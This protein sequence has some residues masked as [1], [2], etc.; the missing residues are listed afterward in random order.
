MEQPTEI[1]NDRRSAE[2]ASSGFGPGAIDLVWGR[3]RTGAPAPGAPGDVLAVSEDAFS[4]TYR[5]RRADG[6]TC[7]IEIQRDEV[8][9]E[10]FP[11]A[12]GGVH[13]TVLNAIWRRRAI[14]ASVDA[15]TTPD[16]RPCVGYEAF[17]PL[18]VCREKGVLFHAP[19]PSS[20]RLGTLAD[21]VDAELLARL[22]LPDWATT[23]A[24]FLYDVESV[25]TTSRPRFW[26]AMRELPRG[27]AADVGSWE[28]FAKELGGVVERAAT[29][30][31]VASAQR[32]RFPCIGCD[33]VSKCFAR[34]GAA[35]SPQAPLASRRLAPVAMHPFRAVAAAEDVASF[36]EHCDILGGAPWPA[37]RTRHMQTWAL[38]GRRLARE[39]LESTVFGRAEAADR[40]TS[41]TSKLGL[42]EAVV[43]EVVKYHRTHGQPHLALGPTSVASLDL[44][45][46]TPHVVLRGGMRSAM[47]EDLF[48]PPPGPPIWLPPPDA[49]APWAHADI[50]RVAEPVATAPPDGTGVHEGGFRFARPA[51]VQITVGRVWEDPATHAVE[52]E[53]SV[54]GLP[55]DS[56]GFETSDR[57]RITVT[58]R[59]W[60]GVALWCRPDTERIEVGRST[61]RAFPARLT[62]AQ[63]LDL[64]TASGDHALFGSAAVFRTWGA[65]YDIH[66]LGMLLLRAVLENARQSMQTLV[67]DVL[68]ALTPFA[69]AVRASD[70]RSAFDELVRVVGTLCRTPPLDR[71]LADVNVCFLPGETGDRGEIPPAVW[72]EVLATI[73]ACVVRGGAASFCADARLDPDRG[74]FCAPAEALLERVRRIRAALDAAPRAGGSPS[75]QVSRPVTAAVPPGAPAR[76]TGPV[77]QEVA[78][79]PRD[80][81]I[82]E[83]ERQLASSAARIERLDADGTALREQ[84]AKA[85]AA[86]RPAAAAPVEEGPVWRGICEA[87]AGSAMAN[88]PSSGAGDPGYELVRTL[89]VEGLETLSGTMSAIAELGG[90]EFAA[91]QRNLQRMVRQA[92]AAAAQDDPRARQRVDEAILVLRSLRATLGGAVSALVEAHARSAQDGSRRLLATVEVGVKQELDLSAAQQR[93]LE[94]LMSRVRSG[95][96]ELVARLYDPVFQEHVR[97]NLA[98]GS[99]AARRRTP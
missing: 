87:V 22:R 25:R 38:P 20:G 55:L 83:L 54:V 36:D 8:Q 15:E 3:D 28:A 53:L 21:C 95:V 4:R 29:G 68:P 63:V 49:V 26:T 27:A 24:R 73:A 33:Q 72:S 76:D 66:S 97:R 85:E 64:R 80:L 1:V 11:A 46:A 86:R 77:R 13:N 81:R 92:I 23:R 18:I 78:P 39:A 60:E 88:V 5:A 93:R 10:S 61:F 70:G 2:F 91:E 32:G 42:F 47:I 45:A 52:C 43:A 51:P 67:A 40:R 17:G 74:R 30:D 62:S 75:R 7:L 98:S 44:F 79:D 48:A 31:P 90:Q 6:T 82:R 58:S 41:L 50:V 59:G 16:G 12:W 57:V 65:W 96:A 84:L 19:S 34:A 99:S 94:D 69:R 14:A 37:F 9:P 35:A 71:A 56:E 89:L